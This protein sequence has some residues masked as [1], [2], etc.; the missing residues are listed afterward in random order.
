MADRHN[1]NLD[2]KPAPSPEPLKSKTV[3][4]HA[5]LELIHNSEADSPLIKQ[6]LDEAAAVGVDRV[7]QICYSV[8][9]SIW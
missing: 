6:A 2:R 5:H 4:S 7:V 9:Q 3:D 1:R 8:E